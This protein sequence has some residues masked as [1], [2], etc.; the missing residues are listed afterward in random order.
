VR[1]CPSCHSVF[2]NEFRTCPKDQSDLLTASELQPGM[3]LRGKYEILGKLGAGGMAAV[4]R[5]RHL[6]F[7]EV[8]AIKVVNN[9]LADDEDFLRRF[10]NEAVVARRLQHPNAVR[11]DDLDMTEDGRP[12]IVMEYVEGQNLREVIRHQG[13]LSLRRS[14]VI[15]RQVAAALAAA[16]ELGIVHRDIKPDNILLTGS[17]ESETAKVLDFGIAKIKESA[18]GDSGA[19][20]TRTGMVVGT[21]QYMSPEQAMGRRGSELDGRADLYSLGV[22]LYEMVTGRLPFESDT[23]MGIILHHLQTPPP[24]PREVRPDLGI[25]DALSGVLMQALQKE[26]GRR[27]ASAT[28]MATALQGVLALPLPERPGS[29]EAASSGASRPPTP[30]PIPFDIDRHETRVMPKTPP[31]PGPSPYPGSPMA[32]RST[33]PP[34]PQTPAPSPTMAGAP[35]S[36]TPVPA[37]TVFSPPPIPGAPTSVFAPPPGRRK[38]RWWLWA[39]A[40]VVLLSFFNRNS[41]RSKRRD[42]QPSPS[43]VAESSDLQEVHDSVI[44]VAMQRALRSNPRTR[45]ADIEVDVDEGV[46]SLSGKAS[47]AAAHDAE[48]MARSIEG[49]KNVVSTIDIEEPERPEK[50]DRTEQPERAE[51]AERGQGPGPGG[52]PMPPMPPG[53]RGRPSADPATVQRLLKE[54]HAAMKAGNATEAMTKFGSVLGMDHDNEEARQGMKDAT[55]LL[56]ENIRKMI[57]HPEPSPR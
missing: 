14:V 35:P 9:R 13:P 31:V 21:P 55:I 5:A 20:A 30:Q 18:L 57:P 29:A 1:Y 42:A 46:V 32:A 19:V 17:G 22:V 39:V 23:A 56:G 49:V 48:A 25:P 45:R 36:W 44:A 2:P 8:R 33:P 26:P 28:A 16:H 47:S 15:A 50:T 53:P 12:F 10:R 51:P 27:F 4:Y 43:P 52:F 7:G 6:A 34:I 54:A 41:S 40:A 3:V 37:P 38:R 24:E 11:V